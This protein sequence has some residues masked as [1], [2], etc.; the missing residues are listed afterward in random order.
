MDLAGVNPDPARPRAER[1]RPGP[2]PTPVAEWEGRSVE[3]W[4]VRWDVPQL[5]VYAS[6]GSTNDLA[7]RLAAAGAPGG[8]TVLADEQ[9][10]G[11]GRQGRAWIAPPGTA[12]LLSMILRP[13]DGVDPRWTGTVPVLVGLAVARAVESL[14]GVR[15]GVKWPNDVVVDERK[16]AGVLCESAITGGRAGWVVAGIG[17]NVSLTDADLPPSVRG[18]ATSL[19]RASGGDVRRADYAGALIH[20]LRS[21]A[22]AAGQPLDGPLADELRSR[23]VLF[24]QS[25]YD[26]DG[27]PLGVGD[28]IE[29][30]GRL[31]V[32][33]P[34][35]ALQ[36]LSAATIRTAAMLHP[37]TENGNP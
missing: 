32:R 34:G 30:D 17:T 35:G 5:F 10:A 24:G 6:V 7:A 23:D 9:T 21:F 3:E 33:S 25:V 26:A 28:G 22:G 4:R 1:T 31:R 19:A 18:R 29:P 12:V 15:A 20:E 8:S 13:G 16:L 14:T 2:E 37:L 11:R 27:S 36:T